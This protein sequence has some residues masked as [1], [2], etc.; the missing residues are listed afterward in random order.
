MDVRIKEP[1]EDPYVARAYFNTEGIFGM[2]P[3]PNGI[4]RVF[5]GFPNDFD[6]PRVPSREFVQD[7]FNKRG[8]HD[9]TVEEVIWGSRFRVRSRIAETFFVPG[10]DGQGGIVLAGD[11]AHTHSPAGGQ[12]WFYSGD[13]GSSNPSRE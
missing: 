1:F 13:R 6:I 10:K 7:I 9:K 3:L 4:H 2:A 8:L 12:V 11:A 5:A